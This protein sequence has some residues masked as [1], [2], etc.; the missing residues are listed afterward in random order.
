MNLLQLMGNIIHETIDAY[1]R[2]FISVVSFPSAIEILLSGGPPMGWSN[3][4]SE[5]AMPKCPC[6]FR[7]KREDAIATRPREQRSRGARVNPNGPGP[8]YLLE[9]FVSSAM[10]STCHLLFRQTRTFDN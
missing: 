1:L 6:V 9:S 4:G 5:P 8:D 2:Y 3:K 7:S 10:I